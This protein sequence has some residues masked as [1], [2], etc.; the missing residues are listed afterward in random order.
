[1]SKRSLVIRILSILFFSMTVKVQAQQIYDEMIH[2]EITDK[3]I[4][5]EP[6]GNMVITQMIPGDERTYTLQLE[7]E[8]EK[9]Q[10]L[11]LKLSVSAE[12]ELLAEQMELQVSQN[13]NVLYEGT[14][15]ESQIG[16]DLGA[17][18]PEET[19]TIQMTFY[20]PKETDN[21]YS[22]Q[23]SSVSIEFTA[24]TIEPAINTAD[25]TKPAVIVTTMLISGVIISYI[26]KKE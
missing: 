9:E 3:G 19:A 12:E 20:L 14:I 8:S 24:Q 25:Y 6:G 15:Q 17:Y 10:R 21:P 18:G 4:Q 1:M 7:N 16:V 13:N 2:I 5:K 26:K 11:Y 22:M 23:Q